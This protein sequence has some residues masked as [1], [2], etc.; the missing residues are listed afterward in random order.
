MIRLNGETFFYLPR[1]VDKNGELTIEFVNT[2]TNKKH[3][4]KRTDL[5][6]NFIYYKVD[7]VELPVGEYE[8]TASI[9]GEVVDKGICAVT[10]TDGEKKIYEQ[11]I[12][13]KIYGK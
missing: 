1:N 13:Y 8:Y 5:S 12:E 9:E 6:T 3:T 10:S 4:V 11:P 2:T 7:T